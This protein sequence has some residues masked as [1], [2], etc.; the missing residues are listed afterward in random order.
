MKHSRHNTDHCWNNSHLCSEEMHKRLAEAMHIYQMALQEQPKEKRE[1]HSEKRTKLRVWCSANDGQGRKGWIFH[2]RAPHSREKQGNKKKGKQ[3]GSREYQAAFSTR[4]AN[5]ED[6][7]LR[8]KSGR[9][10]DDSITDVKETPLT[11]DIWIAIQPTKQYQQRQQGRSNRQRSCQ[12]A[13]KNLTNCKTTLT[14]VSEMVFKK[15]QQSEKSTNRFSAKLNLVY[16]SRAANQ[17]KKQAKNV[18]N[19]RE[20]KRMQ[21]NMIIRDLMINKQ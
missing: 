5:K 2:T 19:R 17:S 18:G 12:Y 10:K 14:W 6:T 16:Q 8:R 3:I 11:N 20:K 15:S 1:G 4:K 9:E 13:S 7:T 21:L